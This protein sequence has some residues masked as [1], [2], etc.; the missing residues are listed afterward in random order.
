MRRIASYTP[1]PPLQHINILLVGG[2]GAGK[3]SLISTVDSLF[4]GYISRCAPNGQGTRSLTTKFRKYRFFREDGKQANFSLFDTM[5]WTKDDFT[6]T[7][8]QILASG[9]I[10]SGTDLS[11]GYFNKENMRMVQDTTEKDKMHCIVFLVPFG[12]QNCEEYIDQLNI[13]KEEVF[14]S[15]EAK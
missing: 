12:V 11:R 5:G 7:E 2:V 8:L 1:P 10:P 13:L 4:C 15:G 3:S 6:P 9:C 14:H